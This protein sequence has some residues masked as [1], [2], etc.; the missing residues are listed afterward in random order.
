MSFQTKL[1][2]KGVPDCIDQYEIKKF[3]YGVAVFGFVPLNDMMGLI[4]MW[5][6]QGYTAMETVIS[7]HLKATFV[8]IKN[9]EDAEAWKKELG[10][11]FDHPDWLFSGDTGISSKTIYA[12]LEDKWYI[13]NRGRDDFDVPSDAD[14]FGRCYRLIKRFPHYEARLNE[15]ADKCSKWKPLVEHWVKL[16]ATFEEEGK[17]DERGFSTVKKMPLFQS[18]IDTVRKS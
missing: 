9:E 2:P 12:I 15:V 14:D 3:R 4:D 16:C 17:L 10:I 5:Q 18:L 13:L 8:L 11:R 1:Y 6:K 7:G